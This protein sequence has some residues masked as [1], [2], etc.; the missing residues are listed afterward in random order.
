MKEINFREKNNCFDEKIKFI[1]FLNVLDCVMFKIDLKSA[2]HHLSQ[3][4]VVA[5]IYLDD[6]LFIV[7]DTPRAP[8]QVQLVVR[9]L[10]QAGFVVNRE[11]SVLIPTKKIE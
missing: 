10:M 2:Y 8:T 4:D 9:H 5:R 3:W 1:N 6:V 7:K 11:K